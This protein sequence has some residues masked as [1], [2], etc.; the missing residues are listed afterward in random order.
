MF[1]CLKVITHFTIFTIDPRFGAN[2]EV[3]RQVLVADLLPALTGFLSKWAISQMFQGIFVCLTGSVK[4]RVCISIRTLELLLQQ[5]LLSKSMNW[6]KLSLRASNRTFRFIFGLLA[7]P[8]SQAFSTK[9]GLTF[10]AFLGLVN[11]FQAY[12]AREE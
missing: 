1:F 9:C 11:H 4:V 8:C 3:L 7:Y 12:L 6:Q 10:L 2:L 5:L